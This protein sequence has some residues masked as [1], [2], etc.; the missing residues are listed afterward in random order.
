MKSRHLPHLQSP[1]ALIPFAVIPLAGILAIGLTS[2][3]GG[4]GTGDNPFDPGPPHPCEEAENCVLEDGIASCA[5]GTVWES[6]ADK[7]NFNCVTPPGRIG[8]WSVPSGGG[9]AELGWNGFGRTFGPVGT[10]VYT[11]LD[12]NGDGLQDLVITARVQPTDTG[13][14]AV[15]FGLADGSPFWFV[16]YGNGR[17]F[18]EN[19]VRFSLPD[20][21]LDGLGFRGVGGSGNDVGEDVWTTVD[22]N[23]DLLPDLVLTARVQPTPNGDT[24]IGFG[25]ADDDPFWFVHFNNGLGFDETGVR[26]TVPDGGRVDRGFNQAAGSGGPVGSDTWSLM[27]MTGDGLVDLV[28]AARVQPTENGDQSRGFG[29]ADDDPFWVVYTNTMVGFAP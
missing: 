14:Q 17:G 28:V 25:L 2:C 10:D 29:L 8:D 12:I 22:L 20:G 13:D 5:D 11:L 7:N 1:L 26:W 19:G 15:G 4:D 27:D 18:D 9:H 3:A 6:R 21:G 24:P 23:G 16:H